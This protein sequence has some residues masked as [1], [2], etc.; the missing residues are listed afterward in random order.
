MSQDAALEKIESLKEQ[1]EILTDAIKTLCINSGARLN[2]LQLAQRL[3]VHRN[4]INILLKRDRLMPRPGSDGKWM[5]DELI[6][7]ELRGLAKKA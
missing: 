2:R 1:V 4:T 5:L 6:E 3:G 7:W